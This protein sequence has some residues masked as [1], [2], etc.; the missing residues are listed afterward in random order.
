[1][2]KNMQR[3]SFFGSIFGAAAV[4]AVAVEAKPSPASKGTVGVRNCGYWT[5]SY[6][7]SALLGFCNKTM[8]CTVTDCPNYNKP[9]RVPVTQTEVVDDCEEVIRHAL[10]IVGVLCPGEAVP[11]SDLKLCSEVVSRVVKDMNDYGNREWPYTAADVR[12]FE[13]ANALQ[14]YYKFGTE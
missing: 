10:I 11:K 7:D 9:L 2:A 12:P 1:M 14:P 13:L 8:R 4:T 6:C 5:C 3:R